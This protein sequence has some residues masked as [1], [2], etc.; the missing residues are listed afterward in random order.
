MSNPQRLKL[1]MILVIWS[2]WGLT[3]RADE[4]IPA[5][6]VLLKEYQALGLPLA[7]TD[8]PL[9]CY[10]DPDHVFWVGF[11]INPENEKQPPCLLTGTRTLEPRSDCP[12]RQI[13]PEAAN[14]DGVY[15]NP[16]ESL[17][18]AMQCQAR[19]WESLA[20]TLLKSGWSAVRN[21]QQMIYGHLPRAAAK[22]KDQDATKAALLPGPLVDVAWSYWNHQL[23]EPSS[24]RADA[25]KYLKEI[26]RQDSRYDGDETRGLLRSLDL[27]L[28]PSQAAPGSAEGL[29][30]DLVDF[31]NAYDF[32]SLFAQDDRYRRLAELGFAAVPALIDHLDDDRL[33]R[34]KMHGFNNFREW[35]LRVRHLVAELL[36]DLAGEDLGLDWVRRQQGYDLKKTGVQMWWDQAR[37]VGEE[38]YLLNKVLNPLSL[39]LHALH[40][41]VT[42]YPHDLPEIYRAHLAPQ[43]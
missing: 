28:V 33:T 2:V 11:L 21:R 37:V 30:D 31:S 16:D 3:T 14:W 9:V 34:A 18:F 12:A 42:K 1:K 17:A 26:L 6:D 41:V 25:A 29:I 15:F 35:H 19:G 32:R 10:G 7:P 22:L 8:A 4:P 23:T 43:Q 20:R 40:V 13:D 38:R 24:N 36:R 39:N 27:A 5:P